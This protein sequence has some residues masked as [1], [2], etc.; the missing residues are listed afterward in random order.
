MNSRTLIVLALAL[1]ACLISV[2]AQPAQEEGPNLPEGAG[3][4]LVARTCSKCHGLE[5]FSADRKS[6]GEWNVIMEKMVDEGLEIEDEDATTVLTYLS[7]YLGKDSAPA[8]VN[9]NKATAK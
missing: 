4:A 9:V 2:T 6:S 8:K 5:M 7:K 1:P 3:K